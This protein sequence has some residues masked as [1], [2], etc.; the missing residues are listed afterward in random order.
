[1][2]ELTK[3]TWIHFN[4]EGKWTDK[5]II[6][7]TENWYAKCLEMDLESSMVHGEFSY[8]HHPELVN[9]T[10]LESVFRAIGEVV[11]KEY[12]NIQEM[13]KTTN[14]MNRDF[15]F[16]TPDITKEGI[17]QDKVPECRALLDRIEMDMDMALDGLQHYKCVKFSQND[18]KAPEYKQFFNKTEM[19]I[20]EV[21][22]GRSYPK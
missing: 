1:M 12:E 4:P 3:I 11:P 20:Y 15:G 16:D 7:Y 14:D 8:L 13:I 2:D 5:L 19:K 6:R 17:L 10:P 22:T 9:L 21:M 18:R